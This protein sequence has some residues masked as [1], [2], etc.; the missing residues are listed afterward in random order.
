MASA[1]TVGSA[2]AA[3]RP[4]CRTVTQGNR[5]RRPRTSSFSSGR[6]ERART[7]RRSAAAASGDRLGSSPIMR[8]EARMAR[9]R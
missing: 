6:V 8:M 4:S 7:L 3:T 2:R 9:T 1:A 5:P